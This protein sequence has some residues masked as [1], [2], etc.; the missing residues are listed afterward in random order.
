MC[1]SVAVCELVQVLSRFQCALTDKRKHDGRLGDT[2]KNSGQSG[3][4]VSSFVAH[5]S[6]LTLLDMASNNLGAVGPNILQIPISNISA[7]VSLGANSRVTYDKHD[8]QG[9][10]VIIRNGQHTSHMSASKRCTKCALVHGAGGRGA[11]AET[12]GGGTGYDVSYDDAWQV[13]WV[14]WVGRGKTPNELRDG[15]LDVG[16]RHFLCGTVKGCFRQC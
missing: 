4:E 2:R 7:T 13:H 1:T 14:S 6:T 8:V 5:T 16:R 12:D 11:R 3:A 9:P 15:K 10:H